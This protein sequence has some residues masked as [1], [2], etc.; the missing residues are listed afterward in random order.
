MKMKSRFKTHIQSSPF[1]SPWSL[2]KRIYI[3]LWSVCWALFC[4]WTPKPLYLW[5]LLWLR[6][7]GC[8]TY[9]K[10]FVHQ[11][12]R[13]QIPWNLILH[14]KACLGD[15]VI[16]Y[17]LGEIEV[18]ARATI[19]QEAYICTGT[20]NFLDPSLALMTAKIIIGEDAFVG[21]RT[22]IMPGVVIG[23]GAVIGACSVVTKDVD[24]WT[25]VAGNP[26]R[27]IKKRPKIS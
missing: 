18:K 20:H 4:R 12:S 5:R 23:K 15:G 24:D 26:A 17:S 7:F 22:F 21:A 9:G 14:D 16:A 10:P 6:L 25:F 27:E 2:K 8:K 13:I 3:F 11:R 19:A 1:D